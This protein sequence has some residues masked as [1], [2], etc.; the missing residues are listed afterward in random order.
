[1]KRLF[2]PTEIPMTANHEDQVIHEDYRPIAP[3]YGGYYWFPTPGPDG[4]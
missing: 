4:V 1:M 2:Q 3:L